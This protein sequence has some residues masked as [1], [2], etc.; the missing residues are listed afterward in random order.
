MAA[1]TAGAPARRRATAAMPRIDATLS[2]PTPTASPAWGPPM[3]TGSASR[4]NC[5]GPGL[6]TSL[7]ISTD[8]EVHTPSS[9][10]CSVKTSAARR[11][12]NA[13]SLIALQPPATARAVATTTGATAA[14]TLT[15]AR[16]PGRRGHGRSTAAARPSSTVVAGSAMLP[17]VIRDEAATSLPPRSTHQP[18]QASLDADTDVAGAAPRRPGRARLGRRRVLEPVEEDRAADR[19]D[20]AVRPQPRQ[21]LPV[22]GRQLGDARRRKPPHVCGHRDQEVPVTRGV[23]RTFTSVAAQ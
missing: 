6:F 21:L 20:V 5:S 14:T 7:P 18:E 16:L 2:S 17:A 13:L 11:P 19:A 15:P 12:K 23:V 1:T 9:G 8:A 10:W 22:V 4:S 3:R